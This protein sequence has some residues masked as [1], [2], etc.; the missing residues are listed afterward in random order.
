MYMS[1]DDDYRPA[2]DNAAHRML[3]YNKIV[4]KTSQY[5]LQY[6]RGMR[7]W[8]GTCRMGIDKC[9]FSVLRPVAAQFKIKSYRVL[10]NDPERMFR[11]IQ[12]DDDGHP[13]NDVRRVDITKASTSFECWNPVYTPVLETSIPDSYGEPQPPWLTHIPSSLLEAIRDKPVRVLF[14]VRIREDSCY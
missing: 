11:D 13:A 2:T 5:D 6:D 9:V 1:V 14:S 4:K 8:I 3:Q 12:D 10:T 7:S